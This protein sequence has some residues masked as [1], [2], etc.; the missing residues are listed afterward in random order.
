PYTRALMDAMPRLTDPSHTTLQAIGG[1]PPDLIDP[2]SGCRFAPRCTL[3]KARCRQQEPA[4][5]NIA[6]KNHQFACWYPLETK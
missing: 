6:G 1:H 4:L 3:A 5:R 2:P